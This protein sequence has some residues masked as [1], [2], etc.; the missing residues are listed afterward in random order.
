[1]ANPVACR[2]CTS[3]V[4][5]RVPGGVWAGRMIFLIEI[6]DDNF[7]TESQ[8]FLSWSTLVTVGIHQPSGFSAE[9][10]M[11]GCRNNHNVILHAYMRGRWFVWVSTR[12]RGCWGWIVGSLKICSRVYHSIA[13]VHLVC[14]WKGIVTLC[15]MRVTPIRSIGTQLRH[16][17]GSY[18]NSSI[19]CLLLIIY[20]IP[21]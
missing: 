20:F 21:N 17:D 19:S 9:W 18:W 4:G 15:L 12:C 3:L 10:I 6:Y 11:K 13:E 16:V 14:V 1:M 5:W 2:N 8:W 7:C